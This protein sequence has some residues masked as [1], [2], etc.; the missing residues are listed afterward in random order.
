MQLILRGKRF[1][2]SLTE[3]AEIL[4]MYDGAE[5]GKIRQLERLV[6][7]IEEI[8][9]ELTARQQDIARTLDE[10]A[11]VSSQCQQRLQQLRP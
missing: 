6:V 4:D 11:E 1:G 5:S 8:N 9:S 2:M 3:I 10:L 7:R